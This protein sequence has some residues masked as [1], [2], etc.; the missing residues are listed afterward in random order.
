MIRSILVTFAVCLTLGLSALPSSAQTVSDPT[1]IVIG[2]SYTLNSAVMGE[3][4]EI[5]IW[6]P[7][8]YAEGDARY[9]VL[10]LLDGGQDQDFHHISGLAQLGGIA[11]TTRDIIVVGNASKDRRR[12]LAFPATDPELKAEYPTAGESAR[13]RRMLAEEVLP[14]VEARFRTDGD[15]A[16][17]GE[18]LAALFVTETFLTAPAMFDH[19]AAISP[20]LWWD[21][22][23]LPARAAEL[24]AAHPAGEHTLWLTIAD[25]GGAMQ[26]GMDTLIAALKADTPDGLTWTYEPRPT[27]THAT[28]YHG[29]ALTALRTLYPRPAED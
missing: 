4:R 11:W 9:P 26:T 18:S 3:A 28:I 10:Y 13:F 16:I 6:L 27:E 8:G 15:T 14:F 12:E 1:L 22:S 24:L 7:P 2:Q 25:E 20:S 5:N 29:A 17:I 21:Q 19:Y 23:S